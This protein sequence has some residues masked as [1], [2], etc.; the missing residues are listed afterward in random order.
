MMVFLALAYTHDRCMLMK[1]GANYKTLINHGTVLAFSLGQICLHFSFVSGLNSIV[2]KL[3]IFYK[4]LYRSYLLPSK[5]ILPQNR[6]SICGD[7]GLGEPAEVSRQRQDSC[8]AQRKLHN[9]PGQQCEAERQ[10]TLAQTSTTRDGCLMAL[11]IA[12]NV[13]ENCCCHW[14]E[15]SMQNIITCNSHIQ[16]LERE[17]CFATS[18]ETHKNRVTMPFQSR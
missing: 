11:T 2:Q 4:L 3:C 13:A 10:P 8:L 14:S 12:K 9:N 17:G 16:I 18:V 6:S 1:S 15:G 5:R 7:A